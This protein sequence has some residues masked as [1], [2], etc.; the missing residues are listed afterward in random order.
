MLTKT[1]QQYQ[2]QFNWISIIAYLSTLFI[3]YQ[4]LLSSYSKNFGTSINVTFGIL[5]L[6]GLIFTSVLA[7]YQFGNPHGFMWTRLALAPTSFLERY[8]SS[9]LYGTYKVFILASFI[10]VLIFLETV[11]PFAFSDTPTYDKNNYKLLI[12][13]IYSSFSIL[14]L[15]NLILLL[16]IFFIVHKK[17]KKSLSSSQSRFLV[18]ELFI[19]SVC[20]SIPIYSFPYSYYENLSHIFSLNNLVLL[21]GAYIFSYTYSIFCVG[22]LKKSLKA[23]LFSIVTQYLLILIV[24]D[25]KLE[26]LKLEVIVFLI[27]LFFIISS[28]YLLSAPKSKSKF[29]TIFKSFKV[30]APYACVIVFLAFFVRVKANYMNLEKSS[31]HIE[32][33]KEQDTLYTFQIKRPGQLYYFPSRNRSIQT[34]TK[35]SNFTK[36]TKKVVDETKYSFRFEENKSVFKNGL[37]FK[38]FKGSKLIDTIYFEQLLQSHHIHGNSVYPKIINSSYFILATNSKTGIA[39]FHDTNYKYYRYQVG[40]SKL[41]VINGDIKTISIDPI[42]KLQHLEKNPYFFIF[43]DSKFN[44]YLDK[45]K[46]E[47][48]PLEIKKFRGFEH[49]IQ[50]PFST[51]ISTTYYYNNSIYFFDSY[52]ENEYDY[53]KKNITHFALHSLDFKSYKSSFKEITFDS[54]TDLSSFRFHKGKL[55]SLKQSLKYNDEASKA[56]T[57]STNKKENF[58]SI[59]KQSLIEI[60]FSGN[61]KTIFTHKKHKHWKYNSIVNKFILN[62][63]NIEIDHESSNTN[64]FISENLLKHYSEKNKP[65]FFYEKQD[66]KLKELFYNYTFAYTRLHNILPSGDLLF[67]QY[68]GDKIASSYTYNIKTKKFRFY[69]FHSS[70]EDSDIFQDNNNRLFTI[71]IIKNKKVFPIFLKEIIITQKMEKNHEN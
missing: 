66:I 17:C 9:L 10:R 15:V 6:L 24:V 37:D 28:Y 11:L 8:S 39:Y 40:K 45:K 57:R 71:P 41:K 62:K 43:K 18:F 7:G 38:V 65:Y 69:N 54:D 29:L 67:T 2:K 49:G 3:S 47:I 1:Y 14:V 16:L 55:Y 31:Y 48:P 23:T 46:I 4:F 63:Q 5:A 21:F 59:Q 58:H 20:L 12:S 33:D 56:F 26:T 42:T 44:L 64:D 13:D 25:S 70:Y 61:I 60:D 68:Y 19:A 34:V 50:N 53:S 32:Y 22:F 35:Q 36:S 30:F 52:I 27:T 51:R